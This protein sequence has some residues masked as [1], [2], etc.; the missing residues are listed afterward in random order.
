[1]I[2]MLDTPAEEGARI[3]IKRD[4]CGFLNKNYPVISWGCRVNLDREMGSAIIVAEDISM[5]HGMFMY[6]PPTIAEMEKC[7]RYIAEE[8]MERFGIRTHQDLLDLP[9]RVDGEALN[10]ARGE[11]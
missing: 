3:M 7:L 2:E 5:D 11:R 8:I 9:R 1:M 10:A 6:I 4:I